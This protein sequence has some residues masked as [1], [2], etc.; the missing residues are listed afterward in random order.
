MA[1]DLAA[2]SVLVTRPGQAGADLCDMVA[3]HGGAA[4]HFPVIAFAEPR[5]LDCFQAAIDAVADQQWLIFISSQAVAASIPALRARWPHLPE[6]VKFAAVGAGTAAA[7]RAAGYIAA[8]YPQNEWSSEGLLDLP[9]FQQI[10]GQRIMIMR[11]EGGREYLE[12][13]LQE[14][15]A[16]V[17]SCLAYRR[18]VPDTNPAVCQEGINRRQFDVVVAGSFE[19][20]SNLKHMLGDECWP[21]LQTLP[22]IVMSERIKNLAAET[23]FQTIWVTPTASQQAILDLILQQKEA[24]CQSRSKR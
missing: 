16:I 6:H 17:T 21:Q 20:V 4:L 9:A 12:K 22:L 24:L 23:G 10:D 7:L 15:G 8:V 2:L 13:I 5:D 3:R 11:G 19:S 14:R 18:I 1:N